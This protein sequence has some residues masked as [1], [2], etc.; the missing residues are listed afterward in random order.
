MEQ[1]TRPDGKRRRRLGLVLLIHFT[2]AFVLMIPQVLLPFWKESFDLSSTAA[3]V[4]GSVFFVAYGVTAIPQSFLLVRIGLKPF[5]LW[6][7][8]LI[9]L[10][11]IAFVLRPTFGLGLVTFFVMGIGVT[12]LQ[13]AGSLVVKQLDD[14]PQKYSRNYSLVLVIIGVGG[15]SGGLI[16]GTIVN[17]LQLPWTTLYYLFAALAGL[18]GLVAVFTPLSERPDNRATAVSGL[19]AYREVMANPGLRRYVL[20]IFIY[21]GVEIGVATWIS[22]FLITEFQVD[23]VDA[24]AVV[25]LYWLMQTIGR[26]LGGF[27]LHYFRPAK[28]LAVFALGCAVS[29]ALAV[30]APTAALVSTGFGLVGFFTSIMYP[31]LFAAGMSQAGRGHENVAAGVLSSAVIGG[32]IAPPLIG[33][34][35][36]GIGSLRLSLAL[37]V[38]GSL[39]YIGTVGI[40]GLL[41]GGKQSAPVH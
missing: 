16:I 38:V 2:F 6:A 31:V 40:R 34:L 21:L 30:L 15:L 13:M 32:A 33:L 10:S 23:K 26:L 19:R 37:I 20:G 28:V 5:T 4:L 27:I 35:G 3:T 14:D 12:A 39:V 18:L 8:L 36:Q 17:R 7:S 1:M 9:L 24:A 22:T 41:Y 25:S 29:L 11:S